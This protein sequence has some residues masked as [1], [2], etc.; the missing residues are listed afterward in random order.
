M[1]RRVIAELKKSAPTSDR[2]LELLA[3]LSGRTLG[4]VT[5][6]IDDHL[7]S[8]IGFLLLGEIA[9][10]ENFETMLTR[11]RH[12]LNMSLS[13]ATALA[14][15]LAETAASIE[16]ASIRRKAGL[17]D[18]PYPMRQRLFAQQNSRCG[19]CG[20]KF[21]D[22]VPTWRQPEE[23]QATLDHRTP[24]RLGGERIENLWVLCGLCNLLKDSRVHVG[25][26]GRLWINNHVY[27]EGQRAVAFWTLWRDRSC[28]VCDASAS[29]TRLTVRLRG[30]GAWVVDNCQAVC[31]A[32]SSGVAFDY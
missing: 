32:H 29:T 9:G 19:V 13:D 16:A 6:E 11:L 15:E 27:W 5:T 23:C 22:E 24:Y 17:R 10:A 20:W 4:D 18:L 7:A 14:Q 2:L 31:V 26:H 12:R 1:N 25:E 30:A 3:E 21:A 8:R 28:S